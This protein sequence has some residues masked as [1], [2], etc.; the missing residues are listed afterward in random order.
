MALEL[1]QQPRGKA[2]DNF[3]EKRQKPQRARLA[4]ERQR[5]KGRFRLAG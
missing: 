5:E 3:G 2:V 1:V 4:L